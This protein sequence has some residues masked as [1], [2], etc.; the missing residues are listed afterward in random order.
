MDLEQGLVVNLN[1]CMGCRACVAACKQERGL[2]PG[3]NGM[4][5]WT[6]GP[7]PDAS[8]PAMGFIPRATEHCSLCQHR[9]DQG[10]RPF[11]VEICPTQALSL[12]SPGK[13]LAR[14]C[15]GSKF[16]LCKAGPVTA[17]AENGCAI[18]GKENGPGGGL[19]PPKPSGSGHP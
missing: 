10:L 9:T 2:G 4:V 1:R 15:S 17:T 16:H 7:C 5:V 3:Q 8:P 6:I 12:L 13:L 19:A 14:I 11:C 18:S